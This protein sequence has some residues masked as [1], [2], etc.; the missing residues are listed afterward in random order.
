M[1][2]YQIDRERWAQLSIYKQLGNI[3]S[4]VGRAIQARR[5]GHEDRVEPAIIR[6]LDLFSATTDQL[7]KEKSH[8]LREVLYARNEFLRL[9]YDGTFEQDAEAI[10][11]YFYY[12]ALAAQKQRGR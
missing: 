6:A 8:R 3:G 7:V 2:S 5:T 4:E 12:F 1:P 11:R 9:F 10:E